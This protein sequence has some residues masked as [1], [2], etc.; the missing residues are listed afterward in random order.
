M[1]NEDV[2]K[3]LIKNKFENEQRKNIN[4]LATIAEDDINGVYE[5]LAND[6][7]IKLDDA[8][9][10]YMKESE[11]WLVIFD[12]NTAYRDYGIN[13]TRNVYDNLK[14]SSYE[15]YI[16]KDILIFEMFIEKMKKKLT[17]EHK[18]KL[19]NIMDEIMKDIGE[20]YYEDVVLSV[21]YK[22]LF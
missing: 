20:E 14:R 21:R 4:I 11:K 13:Q 3:E 16:K 18:E 2:I 7:N 9:Y 8:V 1:I 17:D 12:E 5:L 19:I 15:Y 6:S 22:Y 10:K